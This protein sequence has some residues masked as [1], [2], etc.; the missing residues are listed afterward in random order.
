MQKTAY[1]M[2]I[3][4]WSSDVC[5]SDLFGDQYGSDV[6]MVRAWLANSVHRKDWPLRMLHEHVLPHVQRPVIAMLGL[7]YKEATHS[8][9][10]SPALQLQIGSAWCRARVW[11]YV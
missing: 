4:D 6:G 7:A 11:T 10:N 8:T 5:S 9:K 1:E 2:R 3:S